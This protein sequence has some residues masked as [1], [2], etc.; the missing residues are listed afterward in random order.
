MDF[1]Q[2]PT[3][4]HAMIL[5]EVWKHKVFPIIC[6]LQDFN[7]KSTFLLYMV[8]SGLS[9][10]LPGYDLNTFSL[11]VITFSPNFRFIMKLPL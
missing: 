8:V 7:P 3:L 2:I 10:K 6:K 4:V 1:F 11:W 9:F 5:T